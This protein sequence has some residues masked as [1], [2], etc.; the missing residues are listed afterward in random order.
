VG[1]PGEAG[2]VRRDGKA[3]IVRDIAGARPRLLLF[4]D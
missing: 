2:G 3:V 4:L 1:D